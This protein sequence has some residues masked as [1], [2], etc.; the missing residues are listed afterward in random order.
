MMNSEAY[1]SLWPTVRNCLCIHLGGPMKI[2]RTSVVG[3]ASLH[4]KIQRYYIFYICNF[5][6]TIIKLH[7]KKEIE[8]ISLT[9][10]QVA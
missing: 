9:D 2:R 8:F 7:L 1:E 4:G 3:I 5:C 10:S 6:M